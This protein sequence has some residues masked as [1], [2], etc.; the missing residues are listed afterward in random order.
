MEDYLT[1][2]VTDNAMKTAETE[3]DKNG[4]SCCPSLTFKQ[5]LCCFLVTALIGFGI[6][7]FNFSF[8]LNRNNI[9]LLT[10]GTCFSIASTFFLNGYKEQIKNMCEPVRATTSIV[11]VSSIVATLL[12]AICIPEYKTLYSICYI[13]QMCASF[14]YILSYIPQAQNC[15]KKC[16]SCCYK[17]TKDAIMG[18]KNS[19]TETLV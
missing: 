2:Q 11:L 3:I 14:W 15:F 8:S 16:M 7:I 17:N 5:R 1:K 10:V 4:E 9:I 18:N 6:M 19:Q 12:I 13:I